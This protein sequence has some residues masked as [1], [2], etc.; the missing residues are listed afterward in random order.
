MLILIWA[1]ATA[2]AVPQQKAEPPSCPAG[3]IMVSI[4]IEP[5]RDQVK[6][7][8]LPR[9]E[10]GASGPA[11]LMPACKTEQRKKKDYPMA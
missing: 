3:T 10:E 6:R 4:V 2:I 8:Q 5:E 9:A 11:V 7:G 1:A